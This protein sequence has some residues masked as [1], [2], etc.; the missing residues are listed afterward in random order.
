MNHH[1]VIIASRPIGSRDGLG[2]YLEQ[3]KGLSWLS[4]TQG[5]TLTIRVT[6]EPKQCCGWY[7]IESHE[8]HPCA[9][10]AVVD[11]AHES[12][13]VCRKKTNFN[14]AFYHTTDISDKQ[15]QYNAQPHS[16]YAA[17]FGNGIAKA[18]IM[19]DSRGL[20]RIYEQGALWYAVVAHKNNA[21]EARNQ[22][23]RLMQSGLRESVQKRMKAEVL[24]RVIDREVERSMFAEI[25]SQLGYDPE[26]IGSNLDLFFF[27]TYP[28]ELIE[29]FH[30]HTISGVIVG[31]VGRYLILE[32]N[33]R[34]YGAWLD[35]LYGKTI[36]IDSGLVPIQPLPRQVGLFD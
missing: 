14:P 28:G 4:L 33:G 7:D 23:V 3:P 17:Y 29:S 32:N 22:E 2:V 15:A 10:H 35:T 12:C 25:V 1:G 36:A 24:S 6:D 31:A 13:Y 18:G 21:T 20:D 30:D 26:I 11:E 8:N 9:E 19:S 34:L 5:L 16:V 27:G